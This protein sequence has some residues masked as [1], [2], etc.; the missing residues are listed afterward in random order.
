VISWGFSSLMLFKLKYSLKL[1]WGWV[2]C[3]A[4]CAES[5]LG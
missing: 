1:E 5:Q 4:K 2:V 3:G